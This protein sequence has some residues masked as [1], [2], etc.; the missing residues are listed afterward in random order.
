M[1]SSKGQIWS[2][3]SRRR[4]TRRAQLQEVGQR[5]CTE[6]E[7]ADVLDFQQLRDQATAQYQSLQEKAQPVILVIQD[8]EAVAKL[9]SGAD[10]EKNLELLRSEYQVRRERRSKGP[11]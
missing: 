2:T 9:K 11:C 5:L 10:K 8:P 4:R 6:G 1:I 3:T 7:Q